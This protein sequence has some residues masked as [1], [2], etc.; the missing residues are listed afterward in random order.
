MARRGRVAGVDTDRQMQRSGR[1]A[2]AAEM[3]RN[4]PQRQT[5]GVRNQMIAARLRAALVYYCLEGVVIVH[6]Y[7][8]GY[9]T[10]VAI[11]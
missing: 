4:T 10:G 1:R 11:G 7:S 5:Y 9:E 6:M 2:I 3:P 8:A